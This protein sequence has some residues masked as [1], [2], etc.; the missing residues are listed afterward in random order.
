[1]SSPT[2]PTVFLTQSRFIEFLFAA[3]LPLIGY[4]LAITSHNALPQIWLMLIATGL[5][6]AHILTFN[7]ACFPERRGTLRL[8]GVHACIL[9]PLF[10]FVCSRGH[11]GAVLALLAMVVN[12][13]LYAWIGKRNWLLSL[14]HHFIGGALHVSVGFLFAGGDWRQ[15]AFVGVYFGL[16][17]VG[18]AMH[19]EAID[20]DE[21]HAAGFV[22]GAVRFGFQRWFVLGAVPMTLAHLWLLQQLNCFSAVMLTAFAV[23]IVLLLVDAARRIDHCRAMAFRMNCRILYGL[24]GAGYLVWRFVTL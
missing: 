6:G 10:I 1:M 11:H 7:D 18:G 21:D 14:L 9:A 12:W 17:M 8:V 22:S 13:D 2:R 23:Y 16:C 24:A 19:H 15:A 5:S 3:G 20:V 4:C